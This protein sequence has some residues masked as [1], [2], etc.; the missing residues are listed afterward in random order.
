MKNLPFELRAEVQKY[1]SYADRVSLHQALYEN[2]YPYADDD[3][4]TCFANKYLPFDWPSLSNM[5]QKTSSVIGGSTALRFFSYT[6]FEPNDVDIFGPSRW[7]DEWR[8]YF[9][10]NEFLDDDDDEDSEYFCH[11]GKH[12]FIRGKWRIQYLQYTPGIK[13]RLGDVDNTA[14]A[15]GIYH[16]EAVCLYHNDI[17]AN[18]TVFKSSQNIITKLRMQKMMERGYTVDTEKPWYSKLLNLGASSERRSIPL[19]CDTM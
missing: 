19:R 3:P 8:R 13:H 4:I 12:E 18:K 7:L 6:E 11:F 5:L 15:C 2:R 10:Q 16:N 1:L 9:T 14:N 17:V